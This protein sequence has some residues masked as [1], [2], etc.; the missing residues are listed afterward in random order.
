M[1][2]PQYG[3]VDRHLRSEDGRFLWR[4]KKLGVCA[5]CRAKDWVYD[6]GSLGPSFVACRACITKE[7]ARNL[8]RDANLALHNAKT[9]VDESKQELAAIDRRFA[10]RFGGR[11]NWSFSAIEKAVR[12]HR[13]FKK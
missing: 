8:Q 3:P 10:E 9:A 7:G 4:G 5:F 12:D 13:A 2:A 6:I 1:S 11:V